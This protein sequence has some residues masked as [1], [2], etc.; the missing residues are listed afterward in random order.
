MVDALMLRDSIG[1]VL[2]PVFSDPKVLKVLHGCDIDLG[3]LVTD[4]HIPIV[5]IYDTSRAL[6]EIMRLDETNKAPNLTSFE[7]LAQKFLNL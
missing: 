4:L 1:P 2:A 5:N 6:K 7:Y 3:L